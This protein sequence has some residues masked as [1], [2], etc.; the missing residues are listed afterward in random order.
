MNIEN[1]FNPFW[2][3][4]VEYSNEDKSWNFTLKRIQITVESINVS[5]CTNIIKVSFLHFF[6][7]LFEIKL[8]LRIFRAKYPECY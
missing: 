6:N 5:R 3:I 4:I 7:T 1:P 8:F 2:N